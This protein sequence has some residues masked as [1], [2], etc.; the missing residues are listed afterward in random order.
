MERVTEP[1]SCFS[2]SRRIHRPLLP[3]SPRRRLAAA[4]P[5]RAGGSLMRIHLAGRDPS[6]SRT[7]LEAPAADSPRRAGR[8]SPRRRC[9]PQGPCCCRS[10]R[11]RWT[12]R[13]LRL[14]VHPLVPGRPCS[15]CMCFALPAPAAPPLLLVQ[16]ARRCSSLCRP[17]RSS[18]ARGEASPPLPAQAAPPQLPTHGGG[19]GRSGGWRGGRSSPGPGGAL[20]RI[21]GSELALLSLESA[22][23]SLHSTDPM[24]VAPAASPRHP[25]E[26]CVVRRETTHFCVSSRPVPKM[27]L[28]LGDPLEHD[29]G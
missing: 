9:S 2:N 21:E 15:A 23:I 17:P 13:P 7:R 29:F 18:P 22:G 4:R 16:A 11:A 14:A 10:P 5:R 1:N 6:S 12:L 3:A 28:G 8:S 19:T 25:E 24:L 20:R 27:V 26:I